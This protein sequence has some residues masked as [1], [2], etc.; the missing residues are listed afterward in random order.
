[1]LLWGR[2]AVPV[3]YADV[4]SFDIPLPLT[5]ADS[6]TPTVTAN[7]FAAP[8]IAS[9]N[10]ITLGIAHQW[11]GDLTVTVLPPNGSPIVLFNRVELSPTNDLGS[12]AV[13]GNFVPNSDTN[14]PSF[15]LVPQPYQFTATGDDLAA[16]A[17]AALAGQG[18]GLV[19]TNS[20]YAANT[21]SQGPFPPGVWQLVV[22]DGA[23]LSGGTLASAQLDYTVGNPTNS[24]NWASPADITYGT[25]LSSTQLNA[26]ASANGSTVPGTYVYSP[27]PGTV[28]PAGNGQVLSVVFTPADLTMFSSATN[29]V[30]INVKPAP[31]YVTADDKSMVYGSSAPLLTASYSGFV[32]GDGPAS[33][34]QPVSLNTAAGPA[35]P[36]GAY[37]IAVLGGA[38]PN[39]A[40]TFST[41]RLTIT[42]APLTV[43]ADSKTK[44]YGAA[45]PVLTASYRGFV[46]SDGPSSLS[47]PVVLS[48][49]ATAA[50]SAGTYPISVTGGSSP[51]Y[52]LNWLNGNLMV[53]QAVLNV[54]ADNLAKAYGAPLPALT[55]SYSGFVNGDTAASLVQPV[56]LSTTASASSPAG[57]YPIFALGG[58]SPN[59]TMV[60]NSGSLSVTQAVLVITA[61]NQ[62]KAYGAPLPALTA[63]YS[64]FVN[65]DTA[66]SLT[67]PPALATPATPQ[68]LVGTYPI[69]ITGGASPN[70][71]LVRNNGSLTVTRAVLTAT[72]VDQTK[73]YGAPVPPLTVAYAGFVNGETSSSLL[74]PVRATTSASVT[75]PAGSY[76][77]TLSGGVSPNYTLALR[78]GVLTVTPA[79]LLVRADNKNKVYGG[80]VPPLTANYTG[81]VN[82]DTNL[83]QPVTLSTPALST[84]PAGSYPILVSGGASPN[85]SLVL[86]NGVLTVQKA[87]LLVAADNKAGIYGAALPTLTAAYNGLING[88][89]AASFTQPVTLATTARVGSPAGIYPI[90]VSGGDSPNYTFAFQSGVLT[91]KPAPLSILADNKT[92]V[93][94]APLPAFTATY[95]GFVNGD[96]A[97]NLD[98]PVNFVTTARTNSPVGVYP[99][100]VNGAQSANYAIN[101]VS[102][103]LTIVAPPPAPIVDS[104][105]LQIAADGSVLL[106]VAATNGGSLLLQWSDD[107]QSW[108]DVAVQDP[109]SGQAQFNAGNL[110]DSRQRFFR[111]AILP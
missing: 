92:K 83:I 1:M 46:N 71:L 101:F 72:A 97:A 59:Y 51:N 65:G 58:G 103:T 37:P 111:V 99:I 30:T 21:W 22:A 12:A 7:S 42:R 17:D 15:V 96:T 13:L 67:Q 95:R 110:S 48:T 47:Q 63:S 26:V 79:P 3:S 64:G 50:C 66:A 80:V 20:V 68:S 57:T 25:P 32:N 43:V 45:V 70:Y 54:T 11:L 6:G 106:S 87:T 31:L 85:Y 75:S 69:S 91:I 27:P 33:L 94:G 78:G 24:V 108:H 90:T 35:S 73:T 81:F 29:Q 4:L 61:D 18:P 52:A 55:A 2:L 93:L 76:A 9:V 14:N 104:H 56:T 39:Y 62:T 60:F 88:D 102:G 28:L 89:T 16:A 100:I 34:A 10:S 8:A 53:T 41:G 36:V 105:T 23:D 84:S 5:I 98:Q 109:A 38:S 107:L 40:I 77:I 44:A 82:G 74:Q 49:T 19:P 86:S